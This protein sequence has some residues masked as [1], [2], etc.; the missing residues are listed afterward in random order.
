MM[1]SVLRRG[2]PC[3]A[4]TGVLVVALAACGTE[5]GTSPDAQPTA[6][7]SPTE[8]GPAMSPS[9]LVL[10]RTGGIAGF[11][12]KLTVEPDG[13]VTLT[14]RGKE[15]MTCTVN[16]KTKQR[17]D[18]A[19][20]QASESPAPRARSRD[21]K[22]WATATPDELQLFLVIGDQQVQSSDLGE[23]DQHYREL[24]SVMNDIL[25]SAAAVRAGKDTGAGSAC[26]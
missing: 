7:T 4:V 17:L 12:D 26:S 14:S 15:P 10:H 21:G 9:T 24:F 5:Q 3:A 22:K 6:T 18:A 16:P 8:S 19:A 11:N 20:Q 25:S 1:L 13:T 23:Q 2:L